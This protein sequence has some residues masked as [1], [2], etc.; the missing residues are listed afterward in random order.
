MVD[1]G[2]TVIFE[3]FDHHEMDYF[4]YL[5]VAPVFVQMS[6]LCVSE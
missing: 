2:A 3:R 4:I 6:K 1:A 5:H